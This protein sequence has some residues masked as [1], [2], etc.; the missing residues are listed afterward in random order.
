MKK[1][2][3]EVFSDADVLSVLEA[4]FNSEDSFFGYLIIENSEVQNV[5]LII[6]GHCTMYSDKEF[7]GNYNSL[8]ELTEFRFDV[9]DEVHNEHYIDACYKP[10]SHTVDV[11]EL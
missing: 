7:C 5:Y 8:A 9:E 1:T 2:T 6:N 11:I 10:T 4:R 3:I